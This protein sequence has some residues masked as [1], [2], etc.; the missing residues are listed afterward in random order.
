MSLIIAGAAIAAEIAAD[1]GAH[2]LTARFLKDEDD[3]R[4][5]LEMARDLYDEIDT[6]VRYLDGTR[7]GTMSDA[8][9]LA[10]LVEVARGLQAT[11]IV[12]F[13]GRTAVTSEL[14]AFLDTLPIPDTKITMLRLVRRVAERSAQLREGAEALARAPR[15]AAPM[16][17]G[18]RLE[19]LHED[20]R[21]L[22]LY[23]REFPGIKPNTSLGPSAGLWQK[24]VRKFWKRKTQLPIA[25]PMVERR[26]KWEAMLSRQQ[27]VRD[28]GI[29]PSAPKRGTPVRITPPA[30][31]SAEAR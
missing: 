19:R 22:R 27:R 8:T 1:R 16:R 13:T 29:G 25:L 6:N 5:A 10:D 21:E 28:L 17:V 7:H 23:F 15:H 31:P 12:Q 4:R 3:L 24:L 20:L 14:H 2:A 9:D 30:P 26:K 11:R 18:Q